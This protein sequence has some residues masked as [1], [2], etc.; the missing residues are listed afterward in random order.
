MIDVLVTNNDHLVSTTMHTLCRDL[1]LTI[2]LSGEIS[3]MDVCHDA[4]DTALLL[5]ARH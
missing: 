1:S 5:K 2:N 4:I 3:D